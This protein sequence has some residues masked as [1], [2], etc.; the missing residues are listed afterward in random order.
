[1]GLVVETQC[2]YFAPLAFPQPVEAGIRVAHVGTS[3]VRYEV[4]LFAGQSAQADPLCA[5]KGHLVHVYVDRSMRRP[6]PLPQALLP[7]LALA[8]A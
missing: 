7:A 5:A 1:M 3:S 8:A 2:N 6:L 4:A